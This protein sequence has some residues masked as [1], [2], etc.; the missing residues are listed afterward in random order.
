MIWGERERLI[1]QECNF[2]TVHVYMIREREVE[3][4]HGDIDKNGP[5]NCF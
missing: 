3:Y 2:A 4:R 5:A 1:E